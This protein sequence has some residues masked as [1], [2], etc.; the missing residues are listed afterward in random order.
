MMEIGCYGYMSFPWQ[1]NMVFEEHSSHETVQ[2][3][4]CECCCVFLCLVPCSDFAIGTK[5][6]SAFTYRVHVHYT[7]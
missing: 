4:I 5:L 3:P 6:C 2:M 7:T 1:L